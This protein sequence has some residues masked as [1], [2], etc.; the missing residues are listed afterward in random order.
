LDASLM[1]EKSGEGISFVC[2]PVAGNEKYAER[3]NGD[4]YLVRERLTL[5]LLE[6]ELADYCVENWMLSVVCGRNYINLEI[7]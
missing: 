7:I 3:P 1:E 4:R 2:L 5:L 6:L